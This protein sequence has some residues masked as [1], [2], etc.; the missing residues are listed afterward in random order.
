MELAITIIFIGL[1]VF[2]AYFF[3]WLFSFVRVPDVLMLI[4][5]GILIGPILNIIPP[6]FLGEAGDVVVM[7]ILV[8]I[9][10][11]GS[12][13]LKFQHLQKAI[14]GTIGLTLV[15][16]FLTMAG[17]GVLLWQ[18][19][20]IEII[21]S[22]LIGAIVGGNAAAVVVPL[23]EK[24]KIKEESKTTLFLES[25]LSDVLSIVFTL[26]LIASFQSG[27][28]HISSIFSD[29]GNTLFMAII[30][31]SISA[32][33]WSLFLNKVH[34]TKNSAFSTP[35]FVFIV[36]G[37]TEALGFSGLV[38]VIIFGVVLGNIPLMIS[39]LKEKHKFLH[40]LLHPQPLSTREL[41][42]F[43]EIVFLIKIFF[44]IFIGLSLN[45]SNSEILL[46]GFLLTIFILVIRV[47]SSLL[48]L[49][50]T[51][52]VFD[53]SII[54]VTVPRGL[55]AAVLALIPLQRGIETG[56]IIQ[57]IT[58]SI[59]FFS[60]FLTSILIF[61][62]YNTKVRRFYKTLLPGFSPDPKEGN[63]EYPK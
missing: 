40:A 10:F 43:C 26:A 59:V 15:S 23:I 13:R 28:L 51:T 53:A 24:M 6:N 2:L 29:I 31:G 19:A 1:I 18:F 37:I 33:L 57:D 47:I 7:L 61:L 32:L 45:F 48:I 27:K 22:F 62:L 55:A 25:G 63:S 17:V 44:F 3:S 52:P 39:S 34:N 56:K 36:Y 8:M 12:I 38:S 54:S 9:L 11:E 14:L 5:I 41:S 16:F 60:V 58:Y 46:L 50:K 30:I 49:P 20:Q 35:A 21:S 4:S 42:F